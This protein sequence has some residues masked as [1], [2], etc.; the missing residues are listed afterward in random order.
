MSESLQLYDVEH[1]SEILGLSRVAIYRLFKSGE[2]AHVKVGRLTRVTHAQ[3]S[4]FIARLEEKAE[5]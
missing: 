2:L 1:V 4:A 5:Q 3:L